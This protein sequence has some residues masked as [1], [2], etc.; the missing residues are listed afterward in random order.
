MVKD[1]TEE[2]LGFQAQLDLKL[3]DCRPAKD[4]VDG[5]IGAKRNAQCGWIGI[6]ISIR[7]VVADDSGAEFAVGFHLEISGIGDGANKLDGLERIGVIKLILVGVDN[8][9]VGCGD[10]PSVKGQV[11][12]GN[13]GAS[14]VETIKGDRTNRA[15]T[16]VK[17]DSG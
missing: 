2:K 10:D 16:Q 3:R 13:G 8:V 14:V 5:D 9:R 11:T 12:G 6:G 7:H 4:R 1:G 15:G 17:G